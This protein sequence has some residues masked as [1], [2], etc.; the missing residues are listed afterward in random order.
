MNNWHI[1]QGDALEL[2]KKLPDKFVN[3][4]LTDPPYGIL[5]GNEKIGGDNGTKA[6]RFKKIDWDV[7]PSL[8][9]FMQLIRVSKNQVIFGG[10]YFSDML[11]QSRGW[12]VWDK[13]KTG[14]IQLADTELIW[15]SFNRPNRLIKF[16][17]N[18]FLKDGSTYQKRNILHPTQKPVEL[19]RQLIEENSESGDLVLDPFMGSGSVG[20]ACL[21]SGRRFIGYELNSHYFKIAKMRIED[22]A[23]QMKL[24]ILTE[25]LL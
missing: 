18:G 9:Y 2:M 13:V 17:W 22:E 21:Q 25:V 6:R 5:N 16:A 14:E 20:I 11:P 23:R 4:V 24:P 3:L 12:Y 19:L 7:K 10:E 1:E 15:T 8:D